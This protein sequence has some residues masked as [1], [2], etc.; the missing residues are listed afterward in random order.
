MMALFAEP[1]NSA[2]K[3]GGAPS[4]RKRVGDTG[5]SA[6]DGWPGSWRAVAIN[7][8]DS[9]RMRIFAG[10]FSETKSP[11]NLAR[12]SLPDRVFLFWAGTSAGEGKSDELARGLGAPVAV[13]GCHSYGPMS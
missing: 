4:N 1:S 11:S 7:F 6:Y 9:S 12:S 13:P 3:S 2:I 5:T 10:G 8:P